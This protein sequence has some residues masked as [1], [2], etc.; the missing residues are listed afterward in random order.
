MKTA[1][2]VFSRMQLSLL[3]VKEMM[4]DPSFVDMVSKDTYS[5]GTETGL[6]SGE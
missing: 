3:L 6:N 5:E 1:G 2:S 4:F